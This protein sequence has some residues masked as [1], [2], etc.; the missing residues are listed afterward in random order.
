MNNQPT[1]EQ[2]PTCKASKTEH[3]LVVIVPKN[4]TNHATDDAP[5]AHILHG[6]ALA[7]THHEANTAAKLWTPKPRQPEDLNFPRRFV[8][9]VF[10]RLVSF[11]FPRSTNRAIGRRSRL[12]PSPSNR[13]HR[14]ILNLTNCQLRRIKLKLERK[15]KTLTR[16]PSPLQTNLQL[17]PLLT[18]LHGPSHNAHYVG[19]ARKKLNLDSL[20]HTLI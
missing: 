15:I 4:T 18:R 1:I 9:N 5:R 16:N 6:A 12:R 3:F 17:R 19:R 7:P 20:L 10:T 13:D 2:R 11:I 8:V 14:D